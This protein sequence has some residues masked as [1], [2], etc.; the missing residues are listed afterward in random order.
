MSA[1]NGRNR[2]KKPQSFSSLGFDNCDSLFNEFKQS[3]L[4]DSLES[5]EELRNYMRQAELALIATGQQER[6]SPAPGQNGVDAATALSYARAF[7][8]K[9]PALMELPFAKRQEYFAKGGQA[10]FDHAVYWYLIASRLNV[11]EDVVE[12]LRDLAGFASERYLQDNASLLTDSS[13]ITPDSSVVH[14]MSEKQPQHLLTIPLEK[15]ISEA[16][17]SR[18]NLNNSLFEKL[19]GCAGTDP[20]SFMQLHYACTHFALP[21]ELLTAFYAL[22]SSEGIYTLLRALWQCN[23]DL[24]EGGERGR[25]LVHGELKLSDDQLR[26]YLQRAC[27]DRLEYDDDDFS[28]QA[29]RSD[30]SENFDPYD[31]PT[32]SVM[33]AVLWCLD[34]Q[35]G[36]N[37]VHPGTPPHAAYLMGLSYLYGRNVEQ[38]RLFATQWLE[39]AVLCGHPLAY[40]V[41]KECCLGQNLDP[42]GYNGQFAYVA[43]KSY[44]LYLQQQQADPL[45]YIDFD[46]YYQDEKDQQRSVQALLCYNMLSANFQQAKAIEF[47]QDPQPDLFDDDFFGVL[48]LKPV[49]EEWQPGAFWIE[50]L[51]T[52]YRQCCQSDRVM[53]TGV[54]I[55]C[56]LDNL[57]AAK[58]MPFAL[59]WAEEQE[60]LPLQEEE[61][62]LLRTEITKIREFSDN[63]NLLFPQEI[64]TLLTSMVRQAALQD[65]MYA[66]EC[67]PEFLKDNIISLQEYKHGFYERSKKLALSGHGGSVLFMLNNHLVRNAQ[68]Y[69]EIFEAGVQHKVSDLMRRHAIAQLQESKLTAM[70]L[71]QVYDSLMWSFYCGQSLPLLDLSILFKSQDSRLSQ[72]FAVLALLSDSV[73]SEVPSELLPKTDGKGK[74]DEAGC[75]PFAS[76]LYHLYLAARQGDDEAC[77]SLSSLYYYGLILPRDRM[78]AEY[79]LRKSYNRHSELISRSKIDLGNLF[80]SCYLEPYCA[81][82]TMLPPTQ[83]ALLVLGTLQ[84]HNCI[85]DSGLERQLEQAFCSLHSR[86]T[87]LL[88]KGKTELERCLCRSC[89][90]FVRDMVNV[91]VSSVEINSMSVKFDGDNKVYKSVS[92]LYLPQFFLQGIKELSDRRYL[93]DRLRGAGVYV[94]LSQLLAKLP[95]RHPYLSFCRAM[96][97]LRPFALAPDY[98]RARQ[99]L[100]QCVN[101]GL[102]GAAAPL[103]ARFDPLVF[104]IIRPQDDGAAVP[105][106]KNEVTTESSLLNNIPFIATAVSQ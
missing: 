46:H 97:A 7:A 25:K 51:R 48:Y 63:M 52:L 84:N 37:T 87:E 71:K 99:L 9:V 14:F 80:D 88:Y 101:S 81:E 29:P 4:Q 5:I 1:N 38:N 98:A 62:A 72:S 85:S 73:S 16:I 93:V 28:L 106:K 42:H 34:V 102:T 40:F 33:R 61:G 30:F 31:E 47:A 100:Q 27:S 70:Q 96:V 94:R 60:Q 36:Q 95:E 39:Y 59:C 18:R 50:N 21:F 65:D 75:L 82:T 56:I 58:V 13:D 12:E 22:C 92:S 19:S 79:W 104:G 74:F 10:V 69:H 78:Q 89:F 43:S 41:L 8:K 23:L 49:L 3:D 55:A 64:M 54:S 26:A 11:N 2:S 32:L 6:P 68:D 57:L 17:S 83:E 45:F 66:L 76:L 67:L 24:I 20:D 77:L 90:I 53:L 86:L 91:Q 15:F 35:M 103:Y 105:G 44:L